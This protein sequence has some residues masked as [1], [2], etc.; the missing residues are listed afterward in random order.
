MGLGTRLVVI[1]I[2]NL[3]LV[4]ESLTILARVPATIIHAP[5]ETIGKHAEGGTAKNL[6]GIDASFISAERDER[7]VTEEGVAVVDHR[8]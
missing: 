8:M 6:A 4:R 2:L 7:E 3:V 1:A 5:N